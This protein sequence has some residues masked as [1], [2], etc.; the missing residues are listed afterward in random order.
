MPL[1]A[2]LYPSRGDFLAFVGDPSSRALVHRSIAAFR[3]AAVLPS[4]GAVL[5]L[6]IP[7]VAWSDHRNFP[8]RGIRALMVTDTAPFRDPRYHT[9]DDRPEFVDYERLARAV[10]GME[11][12]VRAL[13]GPGASPAAA[14]G[15]AAG[16]GGG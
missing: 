2:F 15:S 12:V 3:A 7:G 8:A 9:S 6:S 11:A 10:D 4:E 16:S 13:T 1:L 14:A 5:P